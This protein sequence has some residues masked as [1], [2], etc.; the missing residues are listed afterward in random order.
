[1]RPNTPHYVLGVENCITHG[2]HFYSASTIADTCCAIVHTFILNAT[3]TNQAHDET[4]ALLRRMM[5]M[6][7]SH[8][9]EGMYH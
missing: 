3:L 1:M 5:A 7:M 6:W 2:S 8:Y 4:R 9:A